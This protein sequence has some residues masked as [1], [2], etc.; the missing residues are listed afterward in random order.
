MEKESDD[1]SRRQEVFA[2]VQVDATEEV[3]VG[4]EETVKELMRTV[5]QGE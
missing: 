3:L 5:L 4:T 1:L 2:P